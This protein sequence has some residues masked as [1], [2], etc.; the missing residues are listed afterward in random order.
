MGFLDGST[1]NI[2]LDAVLT[3]TGRQFLAR[4]DGSFSIHKFALGDDEVNY[5]IIQKFGR[6]VGKEKIEKNT[7]IFEALTNPNHAQKYKLVSVSNPNLLRLPAL[8]LSG[9][10]SVDGANG[11]VTLGRNVQKTSTVT[12]A[13]TIQNET[14][15]DVEL[16]DQTFIVE[17]SNLFL[18]IQ[19]QTPE[20]IDG[21]QRASYILT[22][23]PVE[24]S[25]GGST[26]QF[27]LSVKSLTDS[28]FAVYGSTANRNIINTYVRVTGV[29]SGAVIE[30]KVSINKTL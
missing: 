4:N 2:I 1:N 17:L 14:S 9:D 23:S 11:V 18:Q 26:L 24:N 10:A 20:N 6:T 21:S 15:I 28:V 12:V 13:Q 30:F 27:T 22:R 7:P 19:S 3:D 5:N 29:Q 25:F 16:R 8:S